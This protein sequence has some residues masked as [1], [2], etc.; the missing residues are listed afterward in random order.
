MAERVQLFDLLYLRRLVLQILFQ[1]VGDLFDEAALGIEDKHHGGLI[2]KGSADPLIKLGIR[3]QDQRF[4]RLPLLV[5]NQIKIEIVIRVL[6]HRQ[7]RDLISADRS[8]RFYI[9]VIAG[10][11]HESPLHVPRHHLDVIIT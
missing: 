3:A 5:Q 8:D 1:S 6:I 2:A 11:G 7:H 4:C 10:R 9:F